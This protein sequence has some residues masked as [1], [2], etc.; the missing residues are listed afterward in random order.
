MAKSIYHYTNQ[1]G[2]M[3][4]LSNRTLWA[5]NALY[6]ND[7]QELKLAY[8][9]FAS[10]L[11]ARMGRLKRSP[12]IH[13]TVKYLLKHL[14]AEQEVTRIYIICFSERYD[15]LNQWRSYCGSGNGYM[16][17][18]DSDALADHPRVNPRWNFSGSPRKHSSIKP[19]WQLVRCVYDRNKQ[20]QKVAD[21]L[22]VFEETLD[23][24]FPFFGKGEVNEGLADRAASQWAT[25]FAREVAPTFKHPAFSDEAEWRLV[26]VN[27][28]GGRDDRVNYR[29]SGSA[30]TP[31]IK[32]DFKDWRFSIGNPM[33]MEPIPK[34]I[35]SS[36]MIRP[37]ITS[38]H[39]VEGFKAFA[40]SEGLASLSVTTSSLPYRSY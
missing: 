4:I 14:K 20:E 17:G 8:D 34:Q 28:V 1:E 7:A 18:F 5:T 11:E 22:E 38:D 6:L 33:L 2:I 27:A 37:H 40:E 12:L 3:G 24:V 29:S 13:G 36:L 35:V 30:I 19:E 25:I 15:D 32:L 23:G 16:I 10:V 21:L 9:V 26:N 31:Y 39:V